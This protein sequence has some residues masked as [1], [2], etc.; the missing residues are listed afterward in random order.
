MASMSNYL[1][2][3]LADFLFRGVSYTPP[4][5]LYI[6]LCTAAPTDASTGSTITEVTGGNYARQSIA[7]NTTNWFTTNGDNA[8]TSSGTNGTVGNSTAI[9]WSSVTWSA[10]VTDVAICDALTGGNVL[11]YSTLQSS[12]TIAPTDSLSFAI[13]SLTIQIDN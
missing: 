5:T 3:K 2:N 13:N 4:A 9:L 1:E 6:A 10:T 11:F 7:S 12:K 8:A